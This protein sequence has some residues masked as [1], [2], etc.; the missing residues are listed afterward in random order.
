MGSGSMC[1]VV[2]NVRICD[3]GEVFG[4]SWV[5]NFY[6]TFH[7]FVF[8]SK[9]EVWILQIVVLYAICIIPSFFPLLS[10]Y[11]YWRTVVLINQFSLCLCSI[12]GVDRWMWLLTVALVPFVIFDRYDVTIF[13]LM[14]P[15]YRLSC[16]D[17]WGKVLWLKSQ[18][19]IEPQPSVG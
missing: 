13:I 11:W 3:V 19:K 17:E 15:S 5:S 6:N 18:Y 16:L 9:D 1:L 14:D 8:V 12:F 2:D 7:F 4:D 10:M